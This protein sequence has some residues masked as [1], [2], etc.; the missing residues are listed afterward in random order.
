MEKIVV[1][2][3]VQVIMAFIA[4]CIEATA[5]KLNISYHEVFQ[6]MKRLDMIEKYIFPNYEALHTESRENLVMDIIE[7]MEQKEARI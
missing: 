1:I 7:Y 5:R 4:T 3:R 2:P 6:R